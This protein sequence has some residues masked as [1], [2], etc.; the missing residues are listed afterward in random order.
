MLYSFGLKSRFE[1][2]DQFVKNRVVIELGS[3]NT[4]VIDEQLTAMLAVNYWRENT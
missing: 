3:G 2:A 4:G 1:Y